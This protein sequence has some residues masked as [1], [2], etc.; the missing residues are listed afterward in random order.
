MKAEGVCEGE[1]NCLKYLKRRVK[2]KIGKKINK[3]L[4]KG[5]GRGGKLDQKVGVLKMADW[6]PLT[7]Y[8]QK[9]EQL[10]HKFLLATAEGAIIIRRRRSKKAS[11]YSSL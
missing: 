2:Q 11:L 4:K 7:N 5:G 3:Y 9:D 6:D 8:G 10:T 1:S